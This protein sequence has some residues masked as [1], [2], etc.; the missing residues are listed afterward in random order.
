MPRLN[1]ELIRQLRKDKGLTQD[2]M[3]RKLGYHSALGYHYLEKGRCKVSADQLAVIASTLN[4][5]IDSL[6]VLD[7]AESAMAVTS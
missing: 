7:G 5:T 2:D 6:Y 4:V 1:L 3:A